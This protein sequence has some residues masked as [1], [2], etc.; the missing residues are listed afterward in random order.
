M[1]QAYSSSTIAVNIPCSVTV[2]VTNE[3]FVQLA[4]A[5]RDLQLERNATVAYPAWGLTLG[6]SY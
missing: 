6:G 1:T 4:I 2:I 5:N 3:E